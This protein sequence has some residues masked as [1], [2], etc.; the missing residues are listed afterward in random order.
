[1]SYAT[2]MV[3]LDGGRPNGALLDITAAVARRQG[4]AVIGIA[5]CQPVQ[6]GAPSGYLDGEFA[7]IARDVAAEELARLAHEFHAHAGL[8]GLTRE[9]RGLPTFA[10]VAHAVA[11][12]ARC[13]DLIITGIGHV[14][15]DVA[16]HADTGAL[17]IHAGRP[18][19]VVPENSTT[20]DFATVMIAWRNSRECRRAV[21]DALPILH[22]AT[23]VVLVTASDE[24]G[25]ARHDL[26]DVA[27]WLARHGIDADRVTTRPSGSDADSL[28]VM[29]DEQGADLIVAGAYGHGRIR[30][31]VFGGVTGDLLLQARRCTMLAH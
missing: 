26:A 6:L 22:D 1:M 15:S 3:H 10:N 29:A 31:W 17:V 27:A 25:A 8:A 16:T 2:I 4:A 19:L 5:A 30:E 13:A 7:V 20:A 14:P 11:D 28:A 18:V 12:Q 24:P 21:A 23:R 9:W